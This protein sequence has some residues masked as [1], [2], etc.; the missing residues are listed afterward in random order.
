MA[1]VLIAEARFYPHLTTCSRPVLALPSK[2]PATAMR[3]SPCPARSSFPARSRWPPRAAGSDAFVALGVVIRGETY[4]F[5]IVAG[6][7]A[8]GLMALTMDGI[9][10]G[11]GILTVENEAQAIV[12]ADPAQANKGGGAAEAA[13]ALLAA[14]HALRLADRQPNLVAAQ[15]SGDDRRIVERIFGLGVALLAILRQPAAQPVLLRRQ[16]PVVGAP[17]ETDHAH[18]AR[19][20]IDQ[21]DLG[22]RLGQIVRRR[23]R[24]ASRTASATRLPDRR[25]T[26]AGRWPS[27]R[28]RP[29]S[30]APSCRFSRPAATWRKCSRR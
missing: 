1:H 21:V 19:R 6:E 3:R 14:K 25:R 29:G 2:R 4:H 5:E 12:R 10:V 13:L 7:S 15:R 24:R 17:R 22:R 23:A 28:R 18:A 16:H 20:Q 9:A 26:T 27:G 8:R 30:P 11:N